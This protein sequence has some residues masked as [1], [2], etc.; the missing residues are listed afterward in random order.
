MQMEKPQIITKILQETAQFKIKANNIINYTC[1]NTE[2]GMIQN[3][4]FLGNLTN[5][6]LERK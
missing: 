6:F 5:I 2:I 4:D 3:K 1:S